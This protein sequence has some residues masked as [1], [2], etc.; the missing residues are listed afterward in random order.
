M[1]SIKGD[2][3][4]PQTIKGGFI[5][6]CH[7]AHRETLWRASLHLVQRS[8]TLLKRFNCRMLGGSRRALT[9]YSQLARWPKLPDILTGSRMI[10]TLDPAAF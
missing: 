3:N 7:V 4:Q 10:L 1:Q 9:F 2:T 5:D 6:L 8:V